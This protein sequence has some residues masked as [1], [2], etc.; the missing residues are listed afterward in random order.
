LKKIWSSFS[1][2]STDYYWITLI[3]L[4]KLNHEF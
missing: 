4:S 3:P 1:R 2:L